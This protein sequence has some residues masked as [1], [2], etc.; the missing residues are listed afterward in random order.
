MFYLTVRLQLTI[1]FIIEESAD[2]FLI[3]RLIIAHWIPVRNIV[4]DQIW[5]TPDMFIWPT[6]QRSEP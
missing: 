4:V 3:H 2:Y 1:I 5:P 6:Y